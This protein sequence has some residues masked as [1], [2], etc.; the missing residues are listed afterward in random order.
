MKQYVILYILD[1]EEGKL[2][3]SS[4]I[5]NRD[6]LLNVALIQLNELMEAS[7]IVKDRYRFVNVI[8]A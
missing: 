3:F 8:E 7:G 5:A 6:V 1:G 2:G 4:E